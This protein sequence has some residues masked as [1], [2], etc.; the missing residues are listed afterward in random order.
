MIKYQIITTHKNFKTHCFYLKIDDE[1]DDDNNNDTTV[2][3]NEQIVVISVSNVNVAIRQCFHFIKRA[4][5]EN[6]NNNNDK[7][8]F[9][10]IIY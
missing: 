9:D 6:G 1:D 10:I 8:F 3:S 7:S 4:K 2:S 5:D